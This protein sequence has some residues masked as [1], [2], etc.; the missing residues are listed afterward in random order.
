[1][2]I[3]GLLPYPINAEPPKTRNHTK[4]LPTYGIAY[5]RVQSIQL[6]LNL[7]SHFFSLIK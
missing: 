6:Y 1:M 5:R 3:T 4:L 7:T 2:M